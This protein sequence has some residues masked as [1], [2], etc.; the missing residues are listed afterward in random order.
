MEGRG[1]HRHDPSPVARALRQ[2]VARRLP[3]FAAC[4][5]ATTAVWDGVLVAASVTH[6]PALLQRSGV[7]SKALGNFFRAHPGTGLFGCYDEMV[8]MNVGATQGWASTKFRSDPGLKL[9]TLAIP[10]EM[11]ASRLSGGGRE[12]MERIGEYRHLAMWVHACRAESIGTVRN[13]FGDKPSIQTSAS[14]YNP[15]A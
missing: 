2:A 8:D 5:L 6:S 4:W 3:L 7:K 11:V 15:A 12:L 13:G 9:E 10:P 1:E 14:A